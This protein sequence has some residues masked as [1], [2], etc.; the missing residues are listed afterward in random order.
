MAEFIDD[1]ITD[2]SLDIGGDSKSS[3]LIGVPGIDMPFHVKPAT[4]AGFDLA[5]ADEGGVLPSQV[6]SAAGIFTKEPI[7]DYSSVFDEAYESSLF[8]SSPN[9][10]ASSSLFDESPLFPDLDP[11][12]VNVESDSGYDDALREYNSALERYK[13][14][15]KAYNRAVDDLMNSLKRYE[16]RIAARTVATLMEL[17]AEGMV[18]NLKIVS[19]E[20]NL[21][22][23]LANEETEARHAIDEANKAHQKRMDEAK[24]FMVVACAYNEASLKYNLSNPNQTPAN[25]EANSAIEKELQGCGPYE[26]DALKVLQEYDLIDPKRTPADKKVLDELLAR[27]KIEESQLI[28]AAKVYQ[29]KFSIEKKETAEF[30]ALSKDVKAQEDALIVEQKKYK[31]KF[32][33]AIDIHRN[34]EVALQKALQEV[35]SR[36][37]ARARAKATLDEWS[38][39]VEATGEVEAS[40]RKAEIDRA[41]SALDA[42]SQQLRE[43]D[44]SFGKEK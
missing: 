20:S 1:L 5:D 34:A 40:L 14:E 12:I 39:E 36:E 11:F 19:Y 28:A 22:P 38:R 4:I 27:V 31:E 6:D 30:V 8:E 17:K 2:V 23:K 25:K 24:E 32:S 29:N 26:T 9:S 13:A 35:K 43:I 18:L 41:K 3:D 42:L 7:R 16:M 21:L 33:A 44:Q 10:N 15:D 37:D